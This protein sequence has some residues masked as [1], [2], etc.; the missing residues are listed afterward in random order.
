MDAYDLFTHNWLQAARRILKPNGA[1]WVIGSYHNIFR[2]GA[3]LQDQQF[4]IQNDVIWRKT[5]AHLHRH[6]TPQKEQ[7]QKGASN[8]KA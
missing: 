4:W 5:T 3:I 8:T 2:V 1:I 6:G 7:W